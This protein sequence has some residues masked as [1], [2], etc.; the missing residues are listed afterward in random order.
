MSPAPGELGVFAG[1]R[2]LEE[3]GR[4]ASGTVYRAQDLQLHREVALKLIPLANPR[5]RQRFLREAQAATRVRHPNLVTVHAAGES[6][7]LGYL[8]MQLVDGEELGLRQV[9]PA[10]AARLAAQ[11]ARALAALHE[12]GIV[13]RD[14]KPS[15]VLLTRDGRLLLAD[16][17]VAALVGSERLTRTGAIVG[18]PL[19]AAPEQLQGDEVDARAD[20]YGAGGILYVLL[21]GQPPGGA[22]PSL[23]ELFER[24]RAL[25]EPPSASGA[26]D[27]VLDRICLRALAPDPAARYPDAAALADALSDYRPGQP[28]ARRRPRMALLTV[29][30]LSFAA[31]CGAAWAWRQ[32]RGLELDEVLASAGIRAAAAR[33]RAQ[34]LQD[35]LAALEAQGPLP[36]SAARARLLLAMEQLLDGGTVERAQA[37]LERA[38]ACPEREAL[39]ACVAILDSR[40]AAPY[41]EAALRRASREVTYLEFE[42]LARLVEARRAANL[43][44]QQLMDVAERVAR[45]EALAPCW[46]GAAQVEL[47]LRHARWLE[48]SSALWPGAPLDYARRVRLQALEAL[49]RADDLDAALVVAPTL[50]RAA[51]PPALAPDLARRVARQIPP[52]GE[53]RPLSEEQARRLALVLRLRAAVGWTDPGALRDEVYKLAPLA[54]NL[55]RRGKLAG[56]PGPG[57][58]LLLALGEAAADQDPALLSYLLELWTGSSHLA[59]PYLELIDRAYP[60]A[61]GDAR[62]V[63]GARRVRLLSVLG[64]HDQAI[65]HGT[66]LLAEHRD[67]PGADTPLRLLTGRALCAR[68]RFADALAVLEGT[69]PSDVRAQAL[70]AVGEH[71]RACAEAWRVLES[72]SAADVRCVLAANVAWQAYLAGGPALA[73]PACQALEAFVRLDYSDFRALAWLA[74]TLW[75]C[76]ELQRADEALQAYQARERLP[77]GLRERARRAGAGG[78]EILRAW[79]LEL[80]VEVGPQI[81]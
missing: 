32:P 3:L 6:E 25:P 47:F 48:A 2:L 9:A 1:Y 20:V 37:Q 27:P 60:R 62:R 67:S 18:T 72:S 68:G 40:T 8:V 5:V 57:E 74:T 22:A 54:A 80:R 33:L 17:G 14:V 75:A 13:H 35:E 23:G 43:D 78:E 51:A 36:L 30:A 26:G 28:A 19:F 15:N 52:D 59:R 38:P 45:A 11:V 58:D 79:A 46:R 24:K 4:G 39:A 41:A 81:R 77:A 55:A 34:G 56:D 7:G 71:P 63:L 61:E 66:A 53:R 65:E 29:A 10:Q 49:V 31:V 64:L 50:G 16:L 42:Q 21:T 76:G 70:G 44:R 12:A 69:P 73:A